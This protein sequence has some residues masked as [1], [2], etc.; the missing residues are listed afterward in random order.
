[1]ITKYLAAFL[2]TF[3]APVFAQTYPVLHDA[4]GLPI[5]PIVSMNGTGYG[6][7]YVNLV[8]LKGYRAQFTYNP[9]FP[10]VPPE[11]G[12]DFPGWKAFELYESSD[13]LRFCTFIM[14]K[15]HKPLIQNG[16]AAVVKYRRFRQ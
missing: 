7:Q 8:S 11:V 16:C 10:A 6:T 9:G 13:C 3:S 5:G 2:I 14:T 15:A 1:M 12:T 4:D